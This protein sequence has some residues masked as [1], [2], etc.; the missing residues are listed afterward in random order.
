MSEISK[1]GVIIY[2]R[3]IQG[4]SE[5]HLKMFDFHVL[6]KTDKLINIG[7][8]GF[9]IVVHVPPIELPERNFNT[10]KLFVMVECLEDAK[11]KAETLGGRAMEGEW[12]NPIFKVCNVADPEGNHIQLRQVK[13]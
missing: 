3:D 5:F 12:S 9:N 2:V 1:F 11:N 4:L 13:S 10:I 8:D 6:H 7:K